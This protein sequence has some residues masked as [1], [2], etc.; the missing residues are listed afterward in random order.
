MKEIIFK[1]LFGFL[2]VFGFNLPATLVK[3]VGNMNIYSKI[4]EVLGFY[5]MLTLSSISIDNRVYL[6]EIEQSDVSI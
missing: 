3:I 1:K 6:E 2:L 4:F 5:F